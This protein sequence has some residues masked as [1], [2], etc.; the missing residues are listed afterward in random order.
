MR[1]FIG[2]GIQDEGPNKNVINILRVLVED[3]DSTVYVPLN[4]LAEKGGKG[5]DPRVIFPAIE[6]GRPMEIK[7]IIGHKDRFNF[8]VQCLVDV[9]VIYDN[10]DGSHEMRDKRVWRN[11]SIIRDGELVIDKL[12]AKL[13]ENSYR[14][15][16]TANLLSLGDISITDSFKYDNTAL[17]TINLEGLP[18]LSSNWARPNVLGFHK[19][20]RDCER[21]SNQLTQIKK[22]LTE[23]A[24][25]KDDSI[26]SE[27]IQSYESSKY[28]KEVECVSY[29]IVENPGYKLPKFDGNADEAFSIVKSSIADM[30]FKCCCIKWAIESA[31]SHRRSPYDWSELYQ[32]KSGSSRYYQETLVDIDGE[33]YRLERC[34]FKTQI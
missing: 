17:Y 30:K 29:S 32:K 34:E 5:K 31:M 4:Y 9:K 21:A 19:M 33:K 7:T 6:S 24:T 26:Y 12:M 18:L 10:E 16:V 2:A 22:L 1:D 25:V 20:L 11:Y 15:L 27:E 28:G 3:K 23:S 8:S 14:D 13:S